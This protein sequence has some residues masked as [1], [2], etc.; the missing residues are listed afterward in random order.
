MGVVDADLEEKFD[1]SDP[2]CGIHFTCDRISN[3]R[4]RKR[5]HDSPGK[6]LG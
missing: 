4:R 2:Q 3:H 6:R 5:R 1:P